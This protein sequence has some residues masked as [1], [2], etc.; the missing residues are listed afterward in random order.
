MKLYGT[1]RLFGR[2]AETY[3]EK[4]LGY[5]PIAYWPLW[6]AAGPT[7]VDQVNSPA[8]DG[9][10]T[11]VTLGQPGIGD[12]NTAPLFDGA[13]DFVNVFSGAFQGAFNGAE[14]TCAIWCRVFNAGVWTDGAFR[15]A[16]M[17]KADNV[18]YVQLAKLNPNQVRSIY[19]A[20]GVFETIARALVTTAWFHYAITWSVVGNIVRNYVDGAMLSSA[21]LGVWVGALQALETT[22][23]ASNAVAPGNP[24]HG[25]LAHA[26]VWD[27]PLTGPQITDLATV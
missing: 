4:V 6:E 25:W 1:R 27:T 3:A 26:A 17:L 18:N 10:Y 20:G 9:A 2:R 14:G 7:A 15:V 11:G 21:G 23:G 22:L 24:W 19:V 16:V 12:G 5:G 8:Q 13:N